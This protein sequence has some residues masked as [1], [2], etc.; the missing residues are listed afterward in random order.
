MKTG[1]KGR[2]ARRAGSAVCPVCGKTI[3]IGV[4]RGGDGSVDVFFRH[5]FDGETL[6]PG[7]RR[8]VESPN[9]GLSDNSNENR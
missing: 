4:P 9:S 3:Q 2:F 6:C 5:R 8:E 7:S 1:R